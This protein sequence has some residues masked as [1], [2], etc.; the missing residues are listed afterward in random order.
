M[1]LLKFITRLD[2]KDGTI[3]TMFIIV[4]ILLGMAVWWAWHEFMTTPPFVDFEKHPIKGIDVSRHNGMINYDAVAE[5]GYEF[6]FIKATEGKN[7]RDENFILN[8]DKALRAGLKIGAYHFFR[9]DVDG[10]SQ[11][12]NFCEMVKDRE[13][14]V[15]AVIDVESHGNASGIEPKIV[16]DRVN[17]MADYL[18]MKGY[19][20]IIYTN[21][22]GYYDYI[23]SK[24]NNYPLWICS[25]TETPINAEWLFWQFNHRGEVPG[26]RGDVDINVFYGNRDEWFRYIGY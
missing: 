20:V 12:R 9:F 11:A 17:S 22:D 4:V 16:S 8:Y 21:K 5:A 26:I 7:H 25:F 23:Y 15:G 10:V 24:V 6:V 1:P 19:K 18:S 13:L 14:P 2:I 3:A